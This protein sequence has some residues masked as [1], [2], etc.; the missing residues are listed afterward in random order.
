MKRSVHLA[1][2]LLIPF[3]LTGCGLKPTTKS[4]RSES[5]VTLVSPMVKA[6]P[7]IPSSTGAT[8]LTVDPTTL[9]STIQADNS[10]AQQ[11]AQ[12]W[13]KDAVLYQVSIKLPSNLAVGQATEVYTYGSS[14]DAYNWWTLNVSQKTSKSIRAIVPKEDYLG[15]TLQPIP[16]KF[17]KMSYVEA[18]QMA[19]TNGGSNFRTQ[20]P[21]SQVTVNLSVSQPKN[22]LW[23]SVEYE[24]IA[25]E[26][27]KILVNPATSE[28]I[29]STLPTLQPVVPS[30]SPL[31]SPAADTTLLEQ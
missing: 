5:P 17:W 7:L 12:I 1:I 24:P 18:L 14:S 25:G 9:E 6:S 11:K 4:S 16:L 27:F 29:T 20:H 28:V 30:H 13:K 15:T 10:L 8:Y 19:E 22:F 23:W 3:F 2:L 26:T 21:D 31:S